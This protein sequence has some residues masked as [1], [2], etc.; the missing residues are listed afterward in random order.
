MRQLP[1]HIFNSRDK[2]YKSKYGAIAAN[3]T[4]T[5]RL[6]LP[7][8]YGGLDLTSATLVLMSEDGQN[9]MRLPLQKTTEQWIGSFFWAVNCTPT[10]PGLYWYSFEFVAGGY[11]HNIYKGKYSTGYVDAKEDKW[12]LTVYSGEQVVANQWK[13]GIMYQIFP[14]RFENSGSKKMMPKDSKI[15]P[16]RATP[17]WTADKDTGLWNIDYFGGDLKGIESKLPYLAS[18]GV[19]I[20]YLNPIFE[21]HSNH[22]YNTADYEHIDPILGKE[23]DFIDLCVSAHKLGMK[24][25]LD[26]VFSHTGDDSI[27]FNKY[28]H[29][30]SVGAYQSKDSPYYSWYKFENWPNQY[31]SWW[32]VPILPEIIEETP[33]YINFIAGEGGVIEKWLELGADGWRLDVADELPDEF[34]VKIRNRIKAVKPDA[35]LLGEVWEDASNKTAYGIR[36]KYLLGSE[37]DSVM[38]YPFRDAIIGFVAND[39]AEDFFEQ[40]LTITENYPKQIVDSLMNPLG[41]HD[42]V[43]ILT[44]LAG[45]DC[46]SLSREDQSAL[47]LTED[48][49]EDAKKLLKIATVLQYT[50]PGFPSIYYGDEVGLEGGKDPFNRK[51]FPWY[52]QDEDLLDFYRKLG[53]VR[54]HKSYVFSDALFIPISAADGVICYERRKTGQWNDS[55]GIVVLVN[56]GDETINYTL[57]LDMTDITTVFS[58]DGVE[59]ASGLVRLPAKSF[60]LLENVPVIK[61]TYRPGSQI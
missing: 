36:R 32:G 16:W 6:L 37:L 61:K 14:D 59:V 27:Y 18:L 49:R 15:V 5:F 24:V 47:A 29:Y 58:S 40:I 57:P 1:E 60:V 42:T 39:N 43:R 26:G 25:I 53:D 54:K 19:D 13:G 8:Q 17:E 56:R 28:G 52:D 7:E 31:K 9:N 50:L 51:G 45:Y 41:T 34:I 11:T 20:L 12:Q 30:P 22:R 55:F 3:Q 44:R 23:E 2:A 33:S 35:I 46:E 21:A 4:V 10:R 38:N 48:E